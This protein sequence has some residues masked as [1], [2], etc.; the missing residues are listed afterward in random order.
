MTYEI[1]TNIELPKVKRNRR[2]TGINKNRQQALDNNERFYQG[3]SCKKGNHNGIRW[4][5]DGH[6]K[7]CKA[8][9]RRQPKTLAAIQKGGRKYDLKKFGLTEEDYQKILKS[10]NYICAICKQSETVLR[11]SKEL[12][13]LAVDHCHDKGHVRGL[14][15]YACNIGIGLFKHNS[16]FLRGAAL[17]CEEA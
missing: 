8:I 2:K 15:C 16:E 17:Y 4:A 10:Q 13:R 5:V 12:K 11:K 3:T 14:L 6:C 7:E 9:M 1:I